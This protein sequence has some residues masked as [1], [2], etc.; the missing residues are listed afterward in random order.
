VEIEPPRFIALDIALTVCVKKGYFRSDV[1]E[2]LVEVFSSLDLPGGQR[3]YFH[4]DN[5][6]FGQPVYLSRLIARAMDVPGVRWIEI[7][8]DGDPPARFQRWGELPRGEIEQGFI[9][10]GR[11]EIARLDN[12]SNAPENGRIVFHMEGGS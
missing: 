1:K 5:F 3:G 10:I 6:T 9:D 11:L 2:A 8:P 12:D 4:P 7:D